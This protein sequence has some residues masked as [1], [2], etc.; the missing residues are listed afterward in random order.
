MNLALGIFLALDNQKL[1]VI[2]SS[3]FLILSSNIEYIFSTED[4]VWESIILT[5]Y[6][7]KIEK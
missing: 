2:V 1:N 6:L 5:F 7:L 3:S 4:M